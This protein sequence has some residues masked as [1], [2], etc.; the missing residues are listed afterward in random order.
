MLQSTPGV[1]LAPAYTGIG[2]RCD[3]PYELPPSRTR[4]KDA[5]S[6]SYCIN[7]KWRPNFPICRMGRPRPT[8]TQRPNVPNR[9]APGAN[10]PAGVNRPDARPP[11]VVT[12]APGKPHPILLRYEKRLVIHI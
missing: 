9:P 5:A 11:V 1:S 12:Q 6:I 2:F 10:R 8:V 7:A 4:E 3:P